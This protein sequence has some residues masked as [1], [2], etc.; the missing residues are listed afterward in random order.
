MLQT[1]N[2]PNMWKIYTN[3]LISAL[4]TLIVSVFLAAYI[5]IA[6]VCCIIM[7]RVQFSF[8]PLTISCHKA[9]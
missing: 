5:L 1:R 8:H 7:I 6:Q 2:I 9:Q 3:V 4:L